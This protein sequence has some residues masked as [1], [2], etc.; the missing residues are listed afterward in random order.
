[1]RSFSLISFSDFKST[2][3]AHIRAEIEGKGKEY[4]LGVD[5]DE[6]AAYLH[7]KYELFPLAIIQGSEEVLTPTKSK[8]WATDDFR[9]RKYEREVFYCTVRYKYSGSADLFSVKSNPWKMT[10]YEIA[11]NES[12]ETVSFNFTLYNQDA[13][14]FDGAKNRAFGAAFANMGNVNNDI[15][16]IN[17]GLLNTIKIYLSNEKQKHAKENDFFAAINIKVNK[18]AERVFTVPTIK[19]KTV[20]LPKVPEGKEF[21]SEPTMAIKMYNQVIKVI[22]EAGKSME[23]K[24]SL[25]IGKNEEGLRDQ[26]L[27]SLETRF[28]DVTA[29]GETFNR[30]GRSD[31]LLRYAQD[32]TNVF[33]AECKF[34][35]GGSE[36]LEAISQLFDRYLTWRDSKVAVVIFVKN[37]DM[38]KVLNVIKEET[39]NHEYAVK[40]IGEHGESSLSYEFHLPGDE[41]KTVLL[42]VM[43]FHYDK[44][45]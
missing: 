45:K 20:P 4:I 17:T 32:G 29:T 43:A 19:R 40:K 6:F 38:I 15:A 3:L 41:D 5:E 11:V 12:N 23:K 36:Y 42:E 7:S 28:D 25:Y 21:A 39:L 1:M 22:Y 24:P 30:S 37:K 26:F 10:S 14:E 16:E 33:V 18:D 2:W 44:T 35:H 27:F 34:W 9:D 13:T 8:E 31:I